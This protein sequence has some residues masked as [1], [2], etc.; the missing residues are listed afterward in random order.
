MNQVILLVGIILTATFG[1]VLAINLRNGRDPFSP[2]CLV[3]ALY[4]LRASPFI[5]LVSTNPTEHLHPA[6][7]ESIPDL[8]SAFLWYGVVELLGFV[9]L[10]MGIQSS[11]GERMALRLPLLTYTVS[12]RAYG[13]AA[14]GALGIGFLAFLMLLSQVGGFWALVY[15]LDQRVEMMEGLGYIG[16]MMLLSTVGVVMLTHYLKYD[17]SKGRV[18]TLVFLT[19][20]TAA[21]L[22]TGGSRKHAM[23]LVI[24]V[25]LVWHYS[26]KRI[27]HPVR[28]AAII[29]ALMAPYFVGMPLAR[30]GRVEHYVNNPGELAVDISDNMAVVASQLSYVTTYVFVTDHFDLTN[31]WFGRSYLDLLKAPVPRGLMPDKPPLDEGNYIYSL[32]QG[33]QVYP[34]MPSSDL[35]GVGWPPE[36]L[37]ACYM[38]FHVAGVVCGMFLLGV[39]FRGVYTYMVMSRFNLYS[40]LIYQAVMFNFHWSNLRIAQL[41]FIV[42]MITL[43]FMVAMNARLR[44]SIA[45]RGSSSAAAIG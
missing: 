5:I 26:V 11:F 13:I 1:V 2:W 21:M 39:V 22:S 14:F 38:N 24:S 29:G 8:D 16:S 42:L 33:G 9:A 17:Y 23:S 40:L 41:L 43:F 45:S 28:V 10:M 6:L 19:L 4:L 36:T 31:I 12:P 7:L 25:L 30:S 15:N 35:D 3:P 34:G 20:A 32:A 18:A 27:A 44:L 37:G